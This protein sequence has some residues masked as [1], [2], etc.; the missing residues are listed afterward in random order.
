MTYNFGYCTRELNAWA[1]ALSRPTAE[2]DAD[3]VC[4]VMTAESPRHWDIVRPLP[5]S[6]GHKHILTDIDQS[7]RYPIAVPPWSTE[8]AKVWKAFEDHWMGTLG[9]PILLFSD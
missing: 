1:D 4:T 9:V 5:E 8:T 7:S 6:A 2:E 3:E